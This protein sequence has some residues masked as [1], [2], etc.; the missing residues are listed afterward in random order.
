ML[1]FRHRYSPTRS[2]KRV[3]GK[4]H[5]VEKRKSS[6]PHKPSPTRT[7]PIHSQRSRR[8]HTPDALSFTCCGSCNTLIYTDVLQYIFLVSFAPDVAMREWM[9]LGCCNEGM[10]GKTCTR[11]LIYCSTRWTD[12]QPV[13]LPCQSSQIL[14]HDM[15][16]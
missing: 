15:H 14:Q 1:M 8:P 12:N 9:Y 16:Y 10:C 3:K 2:Y 6:H 7:S 11:L 13:C 5:K 4:S